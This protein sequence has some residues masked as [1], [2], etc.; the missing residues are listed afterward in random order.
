MIYLM[1]GSPESINRDS[2]YE[3]W[4]YT[5]GNNLNPLIFTFLKVNNPFSDNDYILE[6]SSGYKTYWLM[7]VENWRQ[8]GIYFN[9]E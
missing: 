5:D 1:F 2:D 8:G 6:R 3:R 4:T 7:G 9:N